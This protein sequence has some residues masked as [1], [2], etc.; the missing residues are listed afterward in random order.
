MYFLVRDNAHKYP[1]TR[2]HTILTE[3]GIFRCVIRVSSFYNHY[4]IVHQHVLILTVILYRQMVVL[5]ESL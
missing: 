3:T 5:R 1:L 2:V 4:R